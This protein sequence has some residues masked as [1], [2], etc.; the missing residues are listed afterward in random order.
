MPSNS[1]LALFGGSKAVTSPFQPYN[2][3]GPEER[4]AVDCVM[5]TGCLS[6][7]VGSWGPDFYGGP[8][9]RAF[10][11]Q[12]ADYFGVQYA[13]SVNSWT[14]GLVCAVGAISIEPG[15]EVIVTPWT[16]CATVTA[17]LHWNAI[18][19]FADIDPYTFNISPESVIRCITSR[20]KAIIAADI[21]GQ[22]CDIVSLMS[23]ASNYDLR[24]ITDSAQSPGAKHKDKY[25]ST[26]SHIGGFSLNYH[27]HIH[28]GEGGMLVTDDIDLCTKMQLIRNHAE[29]VVGSLG[30]HSLV[31][32]IGHNFRMGELEAS[33][34]IEQLKKL[35]CLVKS[36]QSAA[37]SI[38][39]RLSSLAGL[40][41][42]F[43]Q[44]DSSHVYYVYPM[45]LDCGVLGVRRECIVQALEAEGIQGLMSGYAN[46][47]RLPAFR[48]KIAYGSHGFP[49]SL[50]NNPVNYD[51]GIC[52]VAEELHDHSFLGYEM[53]LF[54]MSDN[55]VDQFCSA[56]EKVWA[57]LPA[58]KSYFAC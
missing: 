7:F 33:I 51:C 32:M 21:F 41:L 50:S 13:I 15:D 45:V 56:F 49:W 2:S 9:V 23:I 46:I 57:N 54:S 6:S 11:Q 58:L 40:R 30:D 4:M 48:E 29:A 52:P 1:N 42:P 38:T 31:N 16:M 27:K 19:V 39:R 34:G 53:C 26:A 55:E 8:N 35:D 3:I 17:I 36:R 37:D 22:S 18:P 25:T 43:V 24:V 14:S 28:T 44:E 10:E 12:W 5:S 47:H 20:T